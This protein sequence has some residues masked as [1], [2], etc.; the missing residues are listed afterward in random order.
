MNDK[1]FECICAMICEGSFDPADV[2]AALDN[3][4]YE[5]FGMSCVDIVSA[6]SM[7]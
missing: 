1:E 5:R 4:F 2:P 7:H 6:F 3:M